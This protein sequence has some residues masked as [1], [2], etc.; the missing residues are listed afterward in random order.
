MNTSIARN[1]RV[2][3]F[4]VASLALNAALLAGTIPLVWYSR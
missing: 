4:A 2:I 3:L 1:M